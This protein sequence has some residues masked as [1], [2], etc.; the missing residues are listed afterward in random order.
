MTKERTKMKNRRN[1]IVAFLL[2]CVMILGVGY[3]VL[4]DTLL[5]KGTAEL[6][7]I[8]A[9]KALD[10][11]VY[12]TK[13]EKVEGGEDG[14]TVSLNA[15]DNDI[16]NFNIQSFDSMTDKVVYKFTVYNNGA[17][18]LTAELAASVA[19]NDHSAVFDVDLKWENDIDTIAPGEEAILIVTITP[20]SI[21]T[22]TVV[23]S[24]NIQILATADE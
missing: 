22:E 17:N 18:G 16:A 7:D 21:P 2:I 24:I 10:A 8:N 1:V 13:A 6:S 12:F 9:S 3:A 5:I 15:S 20:D 23:G 4:S 14:D 11:D 19:V